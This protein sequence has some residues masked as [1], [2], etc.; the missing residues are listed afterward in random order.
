MRF[1]L[2]LNGLH[3]VVES[4]G[5]ELVSLT[6]PSDKE[7]IWHGDPAFW[8][9]RNP[10]LFPIVGRLRDG[11]IS[12]DGQPF[13]MAQHGFARRSEFSVLER[14]EDH[15]V[16]ELRENETTLAQYP[17]P[18]SLQVRH[19]LKA[20]GFTTSL[21]VENTGE[22]VMPFCIGAHTAFRCPLEDGARF[23]DYR[24]VFDQPE[25]ASMLLL[26][27]E[28]LISH[29]NREP[30]LRGQD[31]FDLDYA[32]FDRLDTMIFENLRSTGAALVHR[33]SG[34]GVHVRFDGFPMLAFWTPGGKQAPFLCIEP[35]HGCAA[36]DDENGEFADKR[37]CISLR[38]GGVKQLEYHVTLR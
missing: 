31:S 20:D 10:V 28:A 16:M 19:Q 29:Q 38:P 30:L 22:S 32:V 6:D 15:I 4:H 35:W 21:R 23:E 34:H 33:S 3:A 11:S 5:G 37:H 1:S 26:G 17:F 9:G 12:F 36:V 18:F 7:Y 8:S 14:G 24:I 25:N 2:S 27:S 13:R